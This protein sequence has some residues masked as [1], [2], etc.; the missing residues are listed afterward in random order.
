MITNPAARLPEGWTSF[1]DEDGGKL[2]VHRDS[3]TMTPVRPVPDE[4]R[5]ELPEF[6]RTA[7]C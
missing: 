6:T 1:Q 5:T 2:Y 3:N 4:S 7:V